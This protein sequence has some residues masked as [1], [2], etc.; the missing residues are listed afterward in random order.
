MAASGGR[1]VSICMCHDK[2]ETALLPE[3]ARSHAQQAAIGIVAAKVPAIRESDVGIAAGGGRKR[4]AGRPSPCWH[5]EMGS[6]RKTDASCGSP[7]CAFQR[8]KLFA[9]SP[10]RI[11]P[12]GRR[13]CEESRISTSSAGPRAS[14]LHPSFLSSR[15]ETAMTFGKQEILSRK[16]RSRQDSNL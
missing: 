6:V 2:S 4:A 7:T 9:A 14:Q 12:V 11:T 3:R 1:G 10:S 16:W 8:R 15:T 5:G 13:A